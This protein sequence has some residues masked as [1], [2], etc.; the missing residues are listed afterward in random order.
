M[1]VVK[2]GTEPAGEKPIMLVEKEVFFLYFFH[3]QK[4]GM[5]MSR[6]LSSVSGRAA[7]ILLFLVEARTQNVYTKKQEVIL[8][9][10]IKFVRIDEEGNAIPIYACAEKEI[11]TQESANLS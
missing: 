8:S 10:S 11:L 7:T 4:G 2:F 6:M 3:L 9:T 1:L 5:I